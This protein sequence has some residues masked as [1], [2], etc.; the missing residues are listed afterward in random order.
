MVEESRMSRAR[1]FV[2]QEAL[3]SWVADGRVH[4]MGETLFV[5]GVPFSLS[6]AVRFVSEVAGGGDS[7]DLVG[8]VKTLEQLAQ[9]GGEH[10]ADSVVLGDDA[11][12]VVEGFL[13]EPDQVPGAEPVSHGRVVALF[14]SESSL[15]AP[16][17]P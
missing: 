8:R 14:A 3:E 12:E 9:L 7:L 4:V 16:T 6:G 17:S 5:E 13:A 11:Y 10:C 2:P 1:V 15:R